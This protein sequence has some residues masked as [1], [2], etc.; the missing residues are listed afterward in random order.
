MCLTE[1]LFLKVP[2]K[3]GGDRCHCVCVCGG[4]EQLRGDLMGDE[5]EAVTPSSTLRAPLSF[6]GGLL[7]KVPMHQVAP[8]ISSTRRCYIYE[9]VP[10]AKANIM[11]FHS[12]IYIV[13]PRV[14]CGEE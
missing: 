3:A 7:L 11:S 5:G 12:A 14:A 13:L 8:I 1:A 4:M 10:T 2:L 6:L 9:P